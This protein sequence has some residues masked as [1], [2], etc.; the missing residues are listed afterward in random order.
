MNQTVIARPADV[1][2]VGGPFR[3]EVVEAA[4]FRS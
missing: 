1:R 4:P 2:D 3:I